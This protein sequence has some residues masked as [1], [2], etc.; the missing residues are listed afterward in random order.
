[1]ARSSLTFGAAGGLTEGGPL[2][3]ASALFN[4]ETFTLDNG[5]EVVVVTNRRAPV[6][7]NWLWYRIGTADSP[8]AK[9]GLPHFLEHLMFKGT[10]RSRPASSRRSWPGT[11]ATTTPSPATTSPPTS[12]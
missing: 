3:V 5:L 12:R 4:P 10:E 9:S 11:A 2:E 7:A 8:Q 6:V 1:L